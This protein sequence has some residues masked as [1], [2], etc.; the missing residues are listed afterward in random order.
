MLKI[1]I[2]T[3]ILPEHIPNWAQKFGYGDFIHLVHENS[4]CANMMLG[5][6]FKKKQMPIVL[7]YLVN[8]VRET[9]S[10]WDQIILFLLENTF[11]EI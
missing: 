5:D 3:H 6:K 7:K 8:L 9:K 4:C 10:L 2:H 1:D 11:L